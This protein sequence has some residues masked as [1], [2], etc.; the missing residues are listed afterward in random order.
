MPAQTKTPPSAGEFE[1]GQVDRE[2]RLLD[3]K[4]N[5]GVKNRRKNSN[6]SNPFA[7]LTRWYFMFE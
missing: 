4:C 2:S 3:D 7:P 5:D 1:P 6:I